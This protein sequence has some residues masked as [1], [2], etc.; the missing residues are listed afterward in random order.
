[1]TGK[2]RYVRYKV[3]MK[4]KAFYVTLFIYAINMAINN[5]FNLLVVIGVVFV[6]FMGIY[7]KMYLYKSVWDAKAYKGYLNAR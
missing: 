7:H 4:D 1:M 3:N 6:I 2:D 5:W